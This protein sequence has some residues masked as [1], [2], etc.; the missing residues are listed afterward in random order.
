MSVNVV[1]K[2]SHQRAVLRSSDGHQLAP[3]LA[4]AIAA[5]PEPSSTVSGASPW[6]KAMTGV[7]GVRGQLGAQLGGK[8]TGRVCRPP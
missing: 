7:P 3:E 5:L 2:W 8:T 1:V 4:T 6:A